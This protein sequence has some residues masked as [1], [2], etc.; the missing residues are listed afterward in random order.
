MLPTAQRKARHMP[1]GG[2]TAE[3]LEACCG[4]V[5]F[6]PTLYGNVKQNNFPVSRA[7]AVGR[8]DGV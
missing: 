2:P 4:D 1:P 6:L 3:L 5:G 7:R 8:L